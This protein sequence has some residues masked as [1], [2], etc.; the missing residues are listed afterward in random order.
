MTFQRSRYILLWPLYNVVTVESLSVSFYG[1]GKDFSCVPL[2]IA[3]TVLLVSYNKLK[4]LKMKEG[5]WRMN[6]NWWTYIP[7][8]YDPKTAI[9]VV[10]QKIQIVQSFFLTI[11]LLSRFGYEILILSLLLFVSLLT[12]VVIG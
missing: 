12:I 1:N 10:V 2:D 6:E 4:S 11:S 3:S 8:P 9:F 7:P 5:W